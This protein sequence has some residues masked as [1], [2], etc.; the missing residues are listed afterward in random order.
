VSFNQSCRQ[1]ARGGDAQRKEVKKPPQKGLANKHNRAEDVDQADGLLKGVAQ[2]ICKVCG[3]AC[4]GYYGRWGDS[5][6]CNSDCEKIEIE[7][8]KNRCTQ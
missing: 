6:T 2:P 8:Q 1:G 7:R 5:G 4:R 3:N